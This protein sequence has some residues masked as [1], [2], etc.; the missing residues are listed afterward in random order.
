M[1]AINRS[2]GKRFQALFL[3]AFTSLSFAL[4][5]PPSERLVRSIAVTNEG[6]LALFL[7]ESENSILAHEDLWNPA[8]DAL[9]KSTSAG[10]PRRETIDQVNPV[11]TLLLAQEER[12]RRDAAHLLLSRYRPH[13]NLDTALL[14]GEFYLDT[15]ENREPRWVIDF[16]SLMNPL[17]NE[18]SSYVAEFQSTHDE[19]RRARIESLFKL[20]VSLHR[21]GK[22]LRLPQASLSLVITA[23]IRNEI[24]FQNKTLDDYSDRELKSVTPWILPALLDLCRDRD[25]GQVAKDRLTKFYHSGTTDQWRKSFKIR[26]F[27]LFSRLLAVVEPEDD[28]PGPTASAP[29]EPVASAAD[30]PAETSWDEVRNRLDQIAVNHS[31]SRVVTMRTGNTSSR[32]RSVIGM[33]HGKPCNAGEFAQLLLLLEH[34]DL[35]KDAAN[36]LLDLLDRKLV[37]ISVRDQVPFEAYLDAWSRGGTVPA[38]DKI[39]IKIAVHLVGQTA[40]GV[41]IICNTLHSK[42]A[43]AE[44]RKSL[45]SVRIANFSTSEQRALLSQLNAILPTLE[46]KDS[47]SAL[48]KFIRKLKTYAEDAEN[49]SAPCANE[50]E[51]QS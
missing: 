17:P 3:S 31:S 28:S 13:W 44:A 34:K 1:S 10:T 39:I 29:M 24:V 42:A 22:A 7:P 51:G 23:L 47:K 37:P 46:I 30:L 4:A 41:A 35:G 20:Y 12:M 33:T 36:V 16:V 8:C 43:A 50:V 6:F 14:T 45:L 5:T 49:Q 48:E 2:W 19:T 38:S 21:G 40:S 18:V 25:L 26:H 9:K 27:D 11:A 32:S 15:V